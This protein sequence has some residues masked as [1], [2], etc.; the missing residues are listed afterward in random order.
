[1][2]SAREMEDRLAA[3]QGRQPPSQAPPSVCIRLNWDDAQW[4]FMGYLRSIL[5]K[6]LE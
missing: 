5:F 1:M 2:P 3:L 4:F 6:G